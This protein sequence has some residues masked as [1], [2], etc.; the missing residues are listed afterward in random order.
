LARDSFGA[1]LKSRQPLQSLHGGSTGEE[2]K[3]Q[4]HGREA[5]RDWLPVAAAEKREIPPPSSDQPAS[6]KLNLRIPL[7]LHRELQRRA[8][9]EQVSLNQLATMLLARATVE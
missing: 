7:S 8:R 9:R 6:G 2:R 3:P 4:R 1:S 5:T